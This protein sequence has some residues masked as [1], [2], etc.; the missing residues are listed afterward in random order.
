MRKSCLVLVCALV[1]PV[2]AAFAHGEHEG[3]WFHHGHHG[4]H[5]A[6]AL[7]LSAEQQAKVEEIFKEEGEKFKALHEEIH[8][9]LN[10]VLTP[11][12]QAKLEK[13]HSEHK[14]KRGHHRH[15]GGDKGPE[16]AVP[17]APPAP[18]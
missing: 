9:K 13:L 8:G 17:P 6:K 1:L 4:E 5:L 3:P 16:G 14:G 11:E 12:Q 15:W 10:A 7:G 18:N 2:S